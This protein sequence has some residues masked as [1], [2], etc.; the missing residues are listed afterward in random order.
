MLSTIAPDHLEF[1]MKVRTCA[2]LTLF[3]VL[4]GCGQNYL[5]SEAHYKE[6]TGFRIDKEAEIR[7][8]T[9]HRKVIDVL[10]Q[11]RRAMVKK[12][13]GTLKRLISERY[14]DNGATTDTTADDYGS[15]QLA[16]LFELMAQSTDQI[17]YDV[18]LKRVEI[19][20]RVAWV[21]YEY[22]YSYQYKVGESPTWDAGLDVNRLEL[23]DE[24]GEWKIVSGL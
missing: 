8:T 13:V 23:E 10:L 6:E 7:D 2:I 5:R 22:R 20:D 15:D 3:F 9:E 1:T 16:D 4:V 19:K 14:Y 12:D 18:L 17:K 24:D 11:Y 21:D